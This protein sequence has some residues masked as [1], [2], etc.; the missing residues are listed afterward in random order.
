MEINWLDIC[1]LII[2]IAA[3]VRGFFTGFI[4]QAAALAGI[5]LGAFFAGT[6]AEIILPYIEHW[7]ENVEH[8]AA[9]A[10]YLISFIVILIAVTLI[11]R[12]INVLA[13]AVLLDTANKVAGGIFCAVKW[14]LIISVL[15]NLTVIFDVNKSV[16]KEYVRNE[17]LTYPMLIGMV[18]LI[19]PYLHNDII[20][21]P[22]EQKDSIKLQSVS[23]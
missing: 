11:G 6:L 16:I 18:Q 14:T 9:P 12:L 17:S 4:I 7:F 2:C 15:L 19:T 13:K 21:C 3:F 23:L 5:I 20:P 10:S 1:V 8:L 22:E